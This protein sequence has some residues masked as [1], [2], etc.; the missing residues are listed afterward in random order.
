MEKWIQLAKYD[1]NRQ[2]APKIGR[3]WGEKIWATEK[4]RGIHLNCRA[5]WGGCVY[6]TWGSATWE[7]A[8]YT[9]V[10]LWLSQALPGFWG[11]FFRIMCWS[12]KQSF[13]TNI[14]EAFLPVIKTHKW[15]V[16]W[17]VLPHH[18]VQS[19]WPLYP[20]SWTRAVSLQSSGVYRYCPM[21]NGAGS[22]LRSDSVMLAN[23]RTTNQKK[24]GL[25]SGH[26]SVILKHLKVRELLM[27]CNTRFLNSFICS[28]CFRDLVDPHITINTQEHF[29][30]NDTW[31]ECRIIPVITL[32]QRSC[33][34]TVLIVNDKTI[35][36]KAG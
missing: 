31:K 35:T 20:C 24:G 19:V 18:R 22:Q 4:N 23:S 14:I 29:Q 2:N 34:G 11:V 15:I 33:P 30:N 6:S 1:A 8:R 7:R 27:W 3:G 16:N 12:I 17:W 32:H 21:N 26:C 10:N 5:F 36:W 9:A 25:D 13:S 28:W